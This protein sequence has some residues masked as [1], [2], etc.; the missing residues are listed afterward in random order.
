MAL[1]IEGKILKILPEETGQGQNGTWIKRSFVIDTEDK[2]Y[3]KKVH[4]TTWNDKVENI[5]QLKEGDSVK[6]HF[7]AESKEY[8]EKWFTELKAWKLDIK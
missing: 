8:N 1:D 2:K 4:F 5:T 3:P 6:V 7:N